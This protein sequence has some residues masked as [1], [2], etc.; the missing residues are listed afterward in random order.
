M[1]TLVFSWEPQGTGDTSCCLSTFLS[2]LSFSFQQSSWLFN[3][4]T[5]HLK[6]LLSPF[7]NFLSAYC[8]T[9]FSLRKQNYQKGTSSSAF[10]ITFSCLPSSVPMCSAFSPVI[11]ATLLCEVCR[12]DLSTRSC[13]FR[14]HR[15]RSSNSSFSLLTSFPPFLLDYSHQHVGIES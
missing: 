7:P 2:S 10:T 14:L 9:F 8:F 4:F 3:P 11:K 5:F 13:S 6:S 15:H 1:F 12:P